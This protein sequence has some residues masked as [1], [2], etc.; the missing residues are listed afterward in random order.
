MSEPFPELVPQHNWDDYKWGSHAQPDRLYQGPF[1]QELVPGWEVVMATMPSADV[2]PNYGMGLVNY[3]IGDMFPK[4]KPG[5][6]MAQ[7]IEDIVRIPMGARLYIR[8]TWRQMQSR[9]GR[10]EPFEIWKIT[11]ELAEKY[12]KALGFRIMLSNPDI[13]EESLPDFVLEKVPQVA[14]QGEWPGGRAGE[15][16]HHKAHC[17]P[18]YDHPYFRAALAE[19]DALLAEQL[20]G[21]PFIEF[22]DT[23]MYGFWGEGH[24]WPF[25]NS[26]FPDPVTALET[27]VEIFEMQRTHWDRVP[28]VT[29]TQPDLQKVGNAEL[30]ERTIRSGNWLRTDTIFIENQQIEAISNRPA[31]IAAV[32]E[33]GMSDGRLETL[34]IEDGLPRTERVLQHVRDVGANYWS[35]WN[36]HNIH[37]QHVMNYYRQYPDGIDRLNRAIGYRLRPAWVWTYDQLGRVGSHTGFRY[38]LV[39]GLVN[40]GIAGVPGILRLVL[41]HPDGQVIA[42][43]SLDPGYPTPRGVR[44]VRL[45]LP[46][47]LNWEG[48]VLSAEIEV[49]GVRRPLR[50]A[51]R[52]ANPDGSLT[53]R[54]QKSLA[55]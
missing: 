14:L 12:Q 28:L 22:I 54:R 35:L 39:L 18:R 49:K 25:D 29:N 13:A 34:A 40:D 4:V 44:Q 20:N 46:E 31:W 41:C 27:W 3:V 1:P 53:L 15:I 9:P 51:C 19:F 33:E 2:V 43:G 45:I 10:L 37:A 23:Y 55:Y 47:G 17:L 32:C 6:T 50:W 26:P 52:E 24:S 38:G 21:H 48:L 42:S 7:C 11:L 5:E 36:W 16:R 30:V 8:P